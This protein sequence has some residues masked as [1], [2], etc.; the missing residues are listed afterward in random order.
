MD[1]EWPPRHGDF[2]AAKVL[3]SGFEHYGVS[4]EGTMAGAP[5]FESQY[6][7]KGLMAF[8]TTEKVCSEVVGTVDERTLALR[9]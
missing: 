1:L 5:G 6:H 2:E 8:P 4:S 7:F 3:D 9:V